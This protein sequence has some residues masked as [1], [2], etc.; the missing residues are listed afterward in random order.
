MAANAIGG[1]LA[2]RYGIRLVLSLHALKLTF[3]LASFPC[4]LFHIYS[5]I[6]CFTCL[7]ISCDDV[8]IEVVMT[9]QNHIFKIRLG[10]YNLSAKFQLKASIIVAIAS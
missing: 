3:K 4:L 10:L 1:V 6:P 2:G 7:P 8:I 9:I 5:F